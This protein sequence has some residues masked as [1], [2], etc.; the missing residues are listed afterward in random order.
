MVPI[1]Q[2]VTDSA[3]ELPDGMTIDIMYWS[4]AKAESCTDKGIDAYIPTGCL[5]QIHL[6][7]PNRRAIF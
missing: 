2:Q 7:P 3:S 1:L 6:P 5:P 4:E